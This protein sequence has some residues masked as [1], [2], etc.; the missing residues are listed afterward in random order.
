MW[1]PGQP[2]N[3]T[4]I[5][6]GYEGS[7]V[8][9]DRRKRPHHDKLFKNCMNA[10]ADEAEIPTTTRFSSESRGDDPIED[11]NPSS[12]K[13]NSSRK[14]PSTVSLEKRI[15]KVFQGRAPSRS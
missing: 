9:C 10:S 1:F 5:T 13:S 3:A 8:E 15:S 7:A 14:P 2:I 4:V 11:V 6:D 12:S